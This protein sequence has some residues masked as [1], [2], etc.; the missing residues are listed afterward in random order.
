MIRG[1]HDKMNYWE[2]PAG[3]KLRRTSLLVRMWCAVKDFFWPTEYSE[4]TKYKYIDPRLPYGH[5]A[6]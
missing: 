1:R 4:P 5:W 2:C 3:G 6:K